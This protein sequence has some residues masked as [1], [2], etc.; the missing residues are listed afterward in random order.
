MREKKNKDSQVFFFIMSSC[1]INFEN[2]IP[3]EYYGKSIF[4]SDE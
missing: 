2:F 1:V 3:I 4:T